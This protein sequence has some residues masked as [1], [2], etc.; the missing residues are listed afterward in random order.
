MLSSITGFEV[1]RVGLLSVDSVG[2]SSGDS[3][4]VEVTVVEVASLVTILTIGMENDEDVFVAICV[5][6]MG[7]PL[8]GRRGTEVAKESS[9]VVCTGGEMTMGVRVVAGLVGESKTA[10]G[11]TPELLLMLG[12][13]AWKRESAGLLVVLIVLGGGTVELIS[14][15]IPKIS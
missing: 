6:I 9:V 13:N 15:L 5:V 2:D 12:N 7:E 11:L 3:E 4:L 1:V 8:D 10:N 14:C